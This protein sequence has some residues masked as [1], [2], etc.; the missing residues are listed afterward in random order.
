MSNLQEPKDQAV[1]PV[2]SMFAKTTTLNVGQ[3]TVIKQAW[4]PAFQEVP[5]TKIVNHNS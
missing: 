4:N 3:A 1:A 2:T 5:E